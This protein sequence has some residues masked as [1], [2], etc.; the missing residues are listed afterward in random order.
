MS[1]AVK[2]RRDVPVIILNS[3]GLS[4]RGHLKN[5]GNWDP[6]FLILGVLHAQNGKRA[7]DSI[8]YT[9]GNLQTCTID[10]RFC[11]DLLFKLLGLYRMS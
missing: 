5:K 1:A 6:R 3:L 9:G 2:E 11:H 10:L 8:V 4:A 7:K